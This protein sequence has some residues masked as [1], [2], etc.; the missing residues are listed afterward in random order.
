M[1]LVVSVQIAILF[2]NAVKSLLLVLLAVIEV[3]LNAIRPF[4][5]WVGKY[6]TT[7]P[8]YTL[9]ENIVPFWVIH[10]SFFFIFSYLLYK[11]AI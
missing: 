11:W 8:K 7:G 6:M 2:H 3:G 1:P 4:Y 10:V 9:K 5:R